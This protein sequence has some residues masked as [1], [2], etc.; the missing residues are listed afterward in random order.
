MGER[1]PGPVCI[2]CENARIRGGAVG[3][4]PLVGVVAADEGGRQREQ[5][6]RHQQREQHRSGHLSPP[7]ASSQEQVRY[8]TVRNS[9]TDFRQFT[10]SALCTRVSAQNARDIRNRCEMSDNRRG[11]NT[12]VLFTPNRKSHT[13]RAQLGP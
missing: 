11:R 8:P 1:P 3:D 9:L 13:L 12:G 2:A 7:E 4:H 6:G 10:G 5:A